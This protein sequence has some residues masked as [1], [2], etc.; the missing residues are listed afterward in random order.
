M[1]A[2]RSACCPST[3]L[4]CSGSRP[5]MRKHAPCWRTWTNGRRTGHSSRT[6]RGK[7]L[8]PTASPTA[9]VPS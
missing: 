6:L 9:V 5:A 3:R 8:I 2:S 1:I 4:S 7:R